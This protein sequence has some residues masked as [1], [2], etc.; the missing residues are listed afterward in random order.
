[1]LREGE[2][3]AEGGG[4]AQD[5]EREGR[6]QR[7]ASGNNRPGLRVDHIRR[8]NHLLDARHI[9][10]G[11]LV[12]PLRFQHARQNGEDG[13]DGVELSGGERHAEHDEIALKAAVVIVVAEDQV[14][15]RVCAGH[16][17]IVKRVGQ[18]VAVI[19]DNSPHL[20]TGA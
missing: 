12:P 3:G 10:P 8:R 13:E 9:L 11:M 15:V 5:D 1:M 4:R 19:K 2:R 14:I 16:V 18:V 7:C 20:C 6:Q 17:D